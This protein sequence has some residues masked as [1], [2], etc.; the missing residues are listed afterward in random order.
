MTPSRWRLKLDKKNQTPYSK[1]NSVS[2]H[3]HRDAVSAVPLCL[4]KYII[5]LSQLISNNGETRSILLQP[6]QLLVQKETQRCISKNILP[7]P[8]SA[9]MVLSLEA[10]AFLLSS[11]T[12]SDYLYY[13]ILPLY[14]I[15]I[16]L[17]TT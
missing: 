8:L 16:N 11:S 4:D 2:V 7:K 17:L 13:S 5:Y 10:N 14:Y 6:V 1:K 3:K 12:L 9:M 15:L